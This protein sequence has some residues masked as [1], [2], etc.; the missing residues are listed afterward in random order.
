MS[1]QQ[2]FAVWD[3]PLRVFHWALVILIALQWASAEFHWISMEWHYTLG[4][5]ILGLI[6]FRLVWGFV[7]S[8]SA[9]FAYFVR[10][11]GV[12]IDY[13]RA[14]IKGT[15]ERAVSH[16]PLGALSVLALI[17]TVL[18]QVVSGLFLREDDFYAPLAHLVTKQT[19]H[20]AH[21]VHEVGQQVLLILIGLHIVAI[22]YYAVFKKDPLVPA[23][24]H[25]RKELPR[26]PALNF[27]S[28][29]KALVVI[30]LCAAAT[31][32]FVRYAPT[33]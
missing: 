6:V 20:F 24:V 3:W 4:Y 14:T 19:R 12:V 15:A 11:P 21:E 1:Q 23:M 2:G 27:A 33:W 13:L 17:G 22:I 26:D 31:W 18:V 29:G 30:A 9:R 5:V 25:G 7:G 8:T 32:A 10:G 28:A 16:N